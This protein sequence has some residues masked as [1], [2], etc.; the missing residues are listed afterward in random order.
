MN[1]TEILPISEW[2]RFEG[3]VFRRYGMNCTVYDI[4]GSSITGRPHWCNKICP[5][6]KANKDSLAAICSPGNQYFMA[7]TK[8]TGEAVVG[9]CDAGFLKLAVPIMVNRRFFGIAGGCGLML[10]GGEVEAYVIHKS[11]GISEQEILELC[12]DIGVMSYDESRVMAAY[13]EKRIS[14]YVGAYAA[15]LETCH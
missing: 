9:E 12:R 6:I 8:R 11:L 15:A 4:T 7:E 2:S 1:L 10:A 14:D 5:R 3:E 13:I